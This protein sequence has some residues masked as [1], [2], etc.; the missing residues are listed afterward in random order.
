MKKISSP[1]PSYRFKALTVTA[2]F[3]LW[4]FILASA[5]DIFT[6]WFFVGFVAVLAIA[7]QI[8]AKRLTSTLEIF[9]VINTKIFLGIVF[10]FVISLYGILFRILSID[11][12]RIRTGSKQSTYWLPMESRTMQENLGQS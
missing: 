4:F 8:L 5:A 2:G 3:S 12:L 9:A 7:T 11:L 1:I 6:W 10:I